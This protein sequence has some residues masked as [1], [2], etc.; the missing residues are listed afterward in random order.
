M[1]L[2]RKSDYKVEDQVV[3]VSYGGVSVVE[4]AEVDYG[5]DNFARLA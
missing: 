3:S 4:D 2:L 5:A 1:S